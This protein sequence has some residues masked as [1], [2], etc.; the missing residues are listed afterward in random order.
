MQLCN[1]RQCNPVFCAL[2][3]SVICFEIFMV[4]EFN[5]FFLG[6][7]AASDE[8]LNSTLQRPSPSPLSGWCEKTALNFFCFQ[9]SLMEMELV[10]K[11]LDFII[12]LMWLAAWEGCIKLYQLSV[13]CDI[14]FECFTFL[15]WTLYFFLGILNGN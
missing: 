14:F 3:L 10:S 15:Y 4:T 7:Q 11:M 6:R 2:T 1:V 9:I 12:H 5:A 8:I 13:K